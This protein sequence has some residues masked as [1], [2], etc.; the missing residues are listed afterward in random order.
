MIASN[1]TGFGGEGGI[2]AVLVSQTDTQLAYLDLSFVFVEVRGI[3]A[4]MQQLLRTRHRDLIP[5]RTKEKPLH[6]MDPLHPGGVSRSH[7]PPS[8][9]E[10]RLRQVEEW[11]GSSSFPGSREARNGRDG[12]CPGVNGS[13]R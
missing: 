4:R 11:K 3:R 8:E 5:L 2:L 9:T 13:T 1:A 10:P 7:P 12:C 6:S